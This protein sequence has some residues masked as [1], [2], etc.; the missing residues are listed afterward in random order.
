VVRTGDDEDYGELW[1]H[2]GAECDGV[3]RSATWW[4]SGVQWCT[5]TWIPSCS[6]FDGVDDAAPAFA[7]FPQ[8][9]LWCFFQPRAGWIPIGVG[10]A[11]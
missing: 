2:D 5:I 4:H 1:Q 9:Q 11:S 8:S 3:V 7:L 6:R 10:P